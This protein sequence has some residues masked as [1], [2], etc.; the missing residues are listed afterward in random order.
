MD[1]GVER[2]Q[3]DQV[4]IRFPSNKPML[5]LHTPGSPEHV[6]V[7]TMR[8]HIDFPA[9]ERD[10]SVGPAAR[11]TGVLQFHR[12]GPAVI[13]SRDVRHAR[14]QDIGF[15]FDMSSPYPVSRWQ[16]IGTHSVASKLRSIKDAMK[17]AYDQYAE[18]KR[19]HADQVPVFDLVKW[20]LAEYGPLNR[21]YYK[22]VF[23]LVGFSLAMS[24]PLSSQIRPKLERPKLKIPVPSRRAS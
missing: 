5:V 12:D 7:E 10:D 3:K 2:D 15:V 16:G 14:S 20:V 13:I 19:R 1:F 4:F 22:P 17:E 6:L 18:E 21:T 23:K 8:V 9:A 11:G 24:L